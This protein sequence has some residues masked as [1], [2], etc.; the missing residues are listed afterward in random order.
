MSIA[1]IE[2]NDN[3]VLFKC[4]RKYYKDNKRY[5]DLHN[6]EKVAEEGKDVTLKSTSQLIKIDGRFYLYHVCKG[7]DEQT[8]KCKYHFRGKSQH[9][10]QGYTY[11]REN[12]VWFNE[13]IYKDQCPNGSI[14]LR[15]EEIMES[16]KDGEKHKSRRD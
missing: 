3:Y 14:C 1:P 16:V 13:C 10:K 9:C 6:I 2:V 7:L 5:L 12:L 8:G 15:T 4:N 11:L